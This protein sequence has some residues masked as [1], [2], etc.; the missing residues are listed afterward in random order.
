MLYMEKA[1][2]NP[3]HDNLFKGKIFCGDCGITMGCTA[4]NYNSMSYY[5]PNYREREISSR[6]Y[7][8]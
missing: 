5:C 4:G 1:K 3:K 8:I 2:E 7:R 6:T